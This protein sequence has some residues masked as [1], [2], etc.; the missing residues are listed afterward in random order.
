MATLKAIVLFIFGIFLAVFCG[1]LAH[2]ATVTDNFLV[3]M[4]CA[5]MMCAAIFSFWVQ[6]CHGKS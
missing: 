6:I 5:I 1:A 2:L 3:A 4:A